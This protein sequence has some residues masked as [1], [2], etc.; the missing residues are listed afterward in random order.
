MKASASSPLIDVVF[1]ALLETVY[2]LDCDFGPSMLLMSTQMSIDKPELVCAKR[3][4]NVS[5][6]PLSTESEQ[7]QLH[8]RLYTAPLTTR[9]STFCS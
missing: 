4:L 8:A 3:K 5:Q 2:G 6:T 9:G 7:K 1:S